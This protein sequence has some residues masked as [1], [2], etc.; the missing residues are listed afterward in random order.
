MYALAK[1]I[2]EVTTQGFETDV[3]IFNQLSAKQQLQSGVG[4]LWLYSES[5]EATPSFYVSSHARFMTNFF[6]RYSASWFNIGINGLY[7]TRAQQK[8]AAIKA[9]VTK[10]YFLL[11]LK[12]EGYLIK[13]KLSLFAQMDN[14][15]DRKYSDLL[16]SPMPGRWLMGGLKLS[17]AK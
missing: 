12:A 13:E 17:L 15:F 9:E 5:S 14:L 11:N 6:I 8:A 4:I 2:A 7:K 3:Q 1:N 16:G 10:E